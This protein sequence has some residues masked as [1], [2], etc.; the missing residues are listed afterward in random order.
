MP[1]PI[2][3]SR[4]PAGRKTYVVGLDG[5]ELSFKALRLAASLADDMKDNVICVHVGEQKEDIFLA[6]KCADILLNASVKTRR[7]SFEL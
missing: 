4:L 1:K 5:S 6:S 2:S 3:T 7:Q